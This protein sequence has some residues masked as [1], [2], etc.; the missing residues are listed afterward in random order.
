MF[1]KQYLNIFRMR[2]PD[3]FRDGFIFFTLSLAYFILAG[4]PLQDA[5]WDLKHGDPADYRF[6]AEHLFH[7]AHDGSQYVPE[8]FVRWQE[9]LSALPFRPIGVGSFYLIVH[10]LFGGATNVAGRYVLKTLLALA[11]ASLAVQFARFANRYMAFF[12]L[13]IIFLTSGMF[14]LGDLIWAEEL[15]R[16]IFIAWLADYVR[17][18]SLSAESQTKILPQ[19]FY[20]F[21]VPL[22]KTQWLILSFLTYLQYGFQFFKSRSWRRFAFVSLLYLLIPSAI[23]AINWVG[24]GHIGLTAG[25][26]LHE[27]YRRDRTG[28]HF[29]AAACQ[30]EKIIALKTR[31]C[32]ESYPPFPE[33]GLFIEYQYP[34]QNIHDLIL[35]MDDFTR[36][37]REWRLSEVLGVAWES[38][39]N[40]TNFPFQR[41]GSPPGKNLL[42]VIDA[43]SFIGMAT[44]LLFRRT[45]SLAVFGLSLWI[46][47]AISL[48]FAYWNPRY[49]VPMA[50]FPI[51]ISIAVI[52]HLKT[53]QK[54]TNTH[55]TR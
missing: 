45:R 37:K 39:G 7:I 16:I 30:D 53:R 9:L 28:A 18:M 22:L 49:M 14:S 32:Q 48:N 25:N 33:W 23:L 24:W 43:L 29:L 2:L 47:P 13:L 19:F 50:G 26:S 1:V 51:I 52:W 41:E 27:F 42:I 20:A 38:F 46:I 54:S 34:T 31:F 36:R 17:K 8:L 3:G 15:L 55:P 21:C 35:T 5:T 6:L 10:S 44:G 4:A 11:C 12:V 40:T